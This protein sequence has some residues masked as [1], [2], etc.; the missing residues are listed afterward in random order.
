MVEP[1]DPEWLNRLKH[2]MS[3]LW[4]CAAAVSCAFTVSAGRPA[5]VRALLIRL[6]I[7]PGYDPLSTYLQLPGPF[8]V[9][10]VPVTVGRAVDTATW[11]GIDA[12][13]TVILTQNVF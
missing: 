7:S 13:P 6:A 4:P 2:A 12:V 5:P 9:V 10:T 1:S 11:V 8:G 3:V